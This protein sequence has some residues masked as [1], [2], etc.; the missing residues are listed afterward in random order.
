MLHHMLGLRHPRDPDPQRS[1][2]LNTGFLRE[3][4]VSSI[5][6]R[7]VCR[8]LAGYIKLSNEVEIQSSH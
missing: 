4:Q 7:Y 3:K 6:G 8:N 2:A 1:G 5:V